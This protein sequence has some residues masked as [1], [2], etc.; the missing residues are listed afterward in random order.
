MDEE[1]F[2]PL[3]DCELL[4]EMVRALV[5]QPSEV[6]VESRSDGDRKTLHVHV[7]NEDCGKV[8]GKQGRMADVLRQFMSAVG[9]RQG[10][11]LNVMIEGSKPQERRA[12]R[13]GRTTDRA[14]VHVTSRNGYGER[15]T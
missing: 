6:R 13:S 14:S 4:E 9:T 5:S 8:I 1:D 11:Q 10:H 15:R 3:E 2:E 12:R 7:A